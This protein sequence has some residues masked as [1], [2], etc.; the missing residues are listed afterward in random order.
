VKH[1]LLVIAGIAVASAA[2][3]LTPPRYEL[4][5]N[6]FQRIYY[7]PIVFA[8]IT[9]GWRG[10]L[11]ASLASGLLC[12]ATWSNNAHHAMNQ[13][14]EL[15]VFVLVGGIT[16]VL[17]DRERKREMELQR[18]NR[19]LQQSFAQI[20]RADRL[21][22]VGELSASLAHEIRNPLA[23]IEGA[24]EI[25]DENSAPDEIREFRG[26]ILKECRRLNRLL[27]SLL[28][29]ARPRAPELREVDIGRVFD[30]VIELATHAA[31]KSGVRITKE[32]APKL[33]PLLCDSEQ[34]RQV[35]LNLILN[36]AQ[37]MPSGGTIA[38]AA[39]P[40]ESGIEILVRDEG[41][42]IPEEDLDKIF[43]PF[44][45]TRMDGTGLGL[46]VVHQIVT[47]HGGNVT[48]HRNADRGMTFSL[49]FPRAPR[50]KAA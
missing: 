37:A 47:Q 7:L 18:V 38:L 2:H 5:H 4:W 11:P 46:S 17:A 27:T 30:S 31:G 40:H 19:E 26:I 13:Y 8:A 20:R 33:P 12:V 41:G 23:S 21:S 1:I 39:R 48:A 22:A 32:I 6:I 35:M 50:D 24:A 49:V 43:N 10:G 3:T 45:T 42:G 9:F 14:A 29:F 16:G 34:L 44:F 15:V 36:A 28:D 25:V